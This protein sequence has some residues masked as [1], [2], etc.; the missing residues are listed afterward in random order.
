[1][2]PRERQV[3]EAVA[4]G[5]SAE[6]IGRQLRLSRRTVEMHKLRAMRRIGVRSSTEMTRLIVEARAAGLLG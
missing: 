2:S 5:K 4:T 6:D 1:M 3:A